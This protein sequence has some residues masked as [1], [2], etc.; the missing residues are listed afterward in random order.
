[1][2]TTIEQ[3]ISEIAIITGLSEEEVTDTYT[4]D[5]LDRLLAASAC[6]DVDY[7]AP[8]IDSLDLPCDDPGAPADPPSQ[9][10][11]DII[12]T[13]A[14]KDQ[15]PPDSSKCVE[16]VDK[17]NAQV[18]EQVDKHTEH[19]IL[20]NRLYELQDNI[21]PIKFYYRERS[22]HLALMLGIFQPILREIK[23]L[24]ALVEQINSV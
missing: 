18:R 5:Q 15:I 3:L 24:E 1:M 10:I 16:A 22:K 13:I 7:V 19:N 17:V 11:D 4:Q 23:R 9:N 20:L 21:E 6:D 14:E 8:I 2:A 12:D